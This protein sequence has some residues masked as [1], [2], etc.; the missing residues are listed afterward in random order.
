VARFNRRTRSFTWNG[1]ARN[2]R[3]ITSG[4]YF[5]RFRMPTGPGRRDVRRVTL[6]R[7][8]TRFRSRP[9]FYGRS[10]CGLLTSYKLSSAVFGGRQGR[11][12]GIAF[13]LSRAARVTVT[14]RRGTS[15]IVRRFR[16]RTYRARRTHRL[17]LPARGRRRGDYRVTL[18]ATRGTRRAG[19]TLVARRL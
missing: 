19:Q 1:R 7:S 15:T 13:R 18:R 4:R 14:V 10:S 17:V 3:R 6:E 8:A 11:R 9:P 2:A 16:A 5:V 12:L